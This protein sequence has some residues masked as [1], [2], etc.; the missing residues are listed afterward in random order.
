MDRR[1]AI[2]TVR[3]GEVLV[4]GV[5]VWRTSQG[6]LRVYFPNYW[7]GAYH[8]EAVCLPEELRAEVEAD[9][10]SAYKTAKLNVK[11]SNP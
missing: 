8:E 11:S 3:I 10:I 9:V 5:A 1:V 7:L 6:R 2:A 4:R